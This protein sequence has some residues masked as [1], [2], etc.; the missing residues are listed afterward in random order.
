MAIVT[1]NTKTLADIRRSVYFMLSES[2]LSTIF[3]TDNVNSAINMSLAVVYK[4]AN[5]SSGVISSDTVAGQREYTIPDAAL[6]L[7]RV[8]VDT[9]RVDDT[10][11]TPSAYTAELTTDSQGKPT[12]FYVVGNK[13][14]LSP[15]PD[16]V[17]RLYVQYLMEHAPLVEDTD[18][19]LLSDVFINAAVLYTC[20]ILKLKDE[21]FGSADRL[22]DA[23]TSALK[24]ALAIQSG[25][26]RGTSKYAYGGVQ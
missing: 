13:I 5:R 3:T 10:S 15:T 20:Y 18:T 21:E 22:L 12:E 16:G 14:G 26:Y 4:Q 8:L 1:N 2:P 17:Y 25:I 9:A 6:Q 24:S 7:G 23:Y 19:T 11:L